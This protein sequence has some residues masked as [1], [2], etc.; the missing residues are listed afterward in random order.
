MKKFPEYKLKINPECK[1][2][3]NP[4]CKKINSEYKLKIISF[5]FYDEQKNFICSR[6]FS[7]EEFT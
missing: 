3:I 7:F 2:K 5:V 1:L 6:W 4:E